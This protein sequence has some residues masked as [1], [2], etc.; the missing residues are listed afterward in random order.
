MSCTDNMA[1]NTVVI[2]HAK[3]PEE[4]TPQRA[5][6]LCSDNV[7]YSTEDYDIKRESILCADNIAYCT[8]SVGFVGSTEVELAQPRMVTYY[9]INRARSSHSEASCYLNVYEEINH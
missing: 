4:E 3:E 7:A 8:V 1:Y 9:N 5:A 6:I 2:T